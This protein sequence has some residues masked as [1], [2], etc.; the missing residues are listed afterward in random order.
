MN[1]LSLFFIILLSAPT[2]N[3]K[4][5]DE[6]TNQQLLE[7]A[8]DAKEFVLFEGFALSPDG[9]WIA[10]SVR[11]KPLDIDLNPRHTAGGTPT[12][13]AG[14]SIYIRDNNGKVKQ[15][16][17][18]GNSWRPA[19]S[20]NSQQLAFY[21]DAEGS[22]HLWIYDVN[23]DS[24]H[25]VNK[26]PIKASIFPLDAPQWGKDSKTI[27]VPIADIQ[28]DQPSNVNVL[29]DESVSPKIYLSNSENEVN[30]IIKEQENTFL[31]DQYRASIVE[32][33][34]KTGKE[35][36]VVPSS[37]KPFPAF[38]QL[39]P[40]GKWISYISPVITDDINHAYYDL[41]AANTHNN[42]LVVFPLASNLMTDQGSE[43][44]VYQ[45]HPLNDWL[46]YIQDKKLYKIEFN[47][48]EPTTPKILRSELNNL[49]ANPLLFTKNG[50]K[51]VIGANPSSENELPQSFY[52]ITLQDQHVL[53][54]PLHKK[55]KYFDVFKANAKQIWQPVDDSITLHLQENVTGMDGIVRF[56]IN[57]ENT[58]EN[59][60]W[61]VR[62]KIEATASHGK[63]NE[64][65]AIYQDLNTPPNIY[66]FNS[67]FSEKQELT[68]IDPRLNRLS[69]PSI[70][71]FQTRVPL[72]N[73]ELRN[74]QTT[75]LLPNKSQKQKDEKF[76]A[77]V[78][79]YPGANFS[80]LGKEFMG[81]RNGSLPPVLL[82]QKGYAI[83]FPEILLG[84]EGKAGNP[85]QEMTDVLLPQ[86]YHA[87]DNDIVN[88]DQM[89]IM[90]QSYGGY[91]T[92]GIIAKTNLFRAAVA[93]S[94]LYD[95]GSVYGEYS[96]EL[97]DF[98]QVWSENGQGR[99]GS[100][101]WN[102]LF[103][104]LQNSPYYL[105]DN[106][107][108]P[109]LLIHGENDLG[110]ASKESI[111]LFTAL[112]RLKRPTELVLYP[113]EG[114]VPENWNRQNAIDVTNRILQFFDCNLKN[115]CI[116]KTD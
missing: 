116:E 25:M 32:V 115:Q 16:S 41:I 99:M 13:S 10:Y 65:Y 82:L 53:E 60:L 18:K 81:G 61:K 47:E 51:V 52:F 87:I 17:S 3:A 105:A 45:W 54:I 26:R 110:G 31:M 63:E 58:Q 29:V 96:D 111:K 38:F 79:F 113:K 35:R 71:S 67:N 74:V 12:T 86:I 28:Q 91:G 48:N 30:Q 34:T 92:A 40:S 75:I 89:G 6:L 19:W 39:S 62:A 9:K 85:L 88:I 109:L 101:P 7:L 24:S 37:T 33:D 94:G 46:L 5:K 84:P 43:A 80:S 83:I 106:I 95:L 98:T 4:Q 70:T 78:I 14:S 66:R 42:E 23:E 2:L 108:T 76:P 22:P 27:Y 77:I 8:F 20:P 56:T 72:Y 1:I 57:E 11:Q 21:S 107:H 97:K 68:S 64:L 59:V 102:D 69:P 49:I 93:I 114:H 73:G 104:Y 55:W 44:P 100:P 90:G 103:R 36:I 15:I 112:K 50:S